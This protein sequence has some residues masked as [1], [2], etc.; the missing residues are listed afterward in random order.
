MK[1]LKIFKEAFNEDPLDEQITLIDQE[2]TPIN[3]KKI[4]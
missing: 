4:K 1:H 3:I 2:Y